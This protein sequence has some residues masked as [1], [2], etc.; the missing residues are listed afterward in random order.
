ME[1]IRP[2][3]W[4]FCLWI[5]FQSSSVDASAD[6]FFQPANGPIQQEWRNAGSE[7]LKGIAQIMSG[8]SSIENKEFDT[9]QSEI[10]SASSSLS[11]SGDLYLRIKADLKEGRKVDLDRVP[12]ER[13][14]AIIGLLHYYNAEVPHDEIQATELAG[15]EALGLEKVIE[16]EKKRPAD[17][18]PEDVQMLIRNVTRVLQIGTATAELLKYGVEKQ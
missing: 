3:F 12:R 9:A 4:W 5:A 6:A 1:K 8:V 2:T 7:F 17:Y 11:K 16:N 15:S 14:A 13:I 18:S 10:T